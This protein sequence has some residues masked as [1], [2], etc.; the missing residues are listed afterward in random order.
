MRHSIDTYVQ[1]IAH[2]NAEY[3]DT[4]IA[5]YIIRDIED[6]NS[7][8]YEFFDRE[9]YTDE[10]GYE[11]ELTNDQL[12]ELKEYLNKYYNYNPLDSI[13]SLEELAEF[14]NEKDD[15]PV[16]AVEYVIKRNKW[17]TDDDDM[18]ICNDGYNVLLFN[19][20]DGEAVVVRQY[21]K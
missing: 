11:S 4:T 21:F 2:D 17:A 7:S 5:D 20:N 10:V 9:E 18:H 1:S 19:D 13:D 3:I 15:Y 16:D 14:L 6:G 8:P 12:N